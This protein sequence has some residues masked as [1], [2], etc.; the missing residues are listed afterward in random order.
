MRV[1]PLRAYTRLVGAM[2]GLRVPRFARAP[3]YEA[4]SAGLGIDLTEAEHEAAH[5]DSFG[6]LFVRKLRD[7]ARVVDDDSQAVVSPVD[8][9]VSARGVADAGRL[10]Q[11]KGIDYGLAEL[12][13]DTALATALHGGAYL[14]IYLRPR[15]YHRI[16][17]PFALRGIRAWRIAGGLL[18]VQPSIVNSTP[19]VFVRN[20]RLVLH[21]T[22][23]GGAPVA[24]VAVG[25][26]AVGAITSPFIRSDE[27]ERELNAVPIR[28]GDEIAAFNLGSTIVMIA[29]PSLLG[30][31]VAAGEVRMGQ[32]IGR[33][34]GPA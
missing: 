13:G 11:A 32:A 17:A 24:L 1:A 23:P 12:L 22:T 14:T 21:F 7:G 18:P 19:G 30:L 8:G 25:A 3:L 26:A 34:L 28:K 9:V 6:E 15:D 10:I 5:Y 2:A 16:H 27:V 33:L 20:E 4:L 31:H 29:A